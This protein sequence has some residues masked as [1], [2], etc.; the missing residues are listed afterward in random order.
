MRPVE[1]ADADL[2]R[3]VATRGVTHVH[4]KV[5]RLDALGER[6]HLDGRVLRLIVVMIGLTAEREERGQEEESH[7]SSWSI[8]SA[9]GT[10]SAWTAPRGQRRAGESAVRARARSR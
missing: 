10:V 5:G 2:D 8:G 1:L 7:E 3:D 9:A 6:R 4:A